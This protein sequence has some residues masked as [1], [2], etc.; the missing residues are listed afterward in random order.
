[1][2]KVPSLRRPCH[3]GDTMS[4]IS[5]YVA[6]ATLL[7]AG[8]AAAPQPTPTTAD[9]T[10]ANATAPPAGSG[11]ATLAV[12]PDAVLDVAQVNASTAPPLICREMLYPNYNVIETVYL[13]ER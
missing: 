5:A 10:A 7:V 4:K 2:E 13:L 3:G 11:D 1:M 9:L 6:V 8:C 12:F